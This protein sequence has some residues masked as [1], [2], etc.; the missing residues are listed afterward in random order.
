MNDHDWLLT[1]CQW[2]FSKL[3]DGLYSYLYDGMMMN[4]R[5]LGV[6]FDGCYDVVVCRSFML[7]VNLKRTLFH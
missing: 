3:V 4:Q 2:P 7:N 6:Q 5:W 1:T